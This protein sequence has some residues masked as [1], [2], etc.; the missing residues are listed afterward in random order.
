MGRRGKESPSGAVGARPVIVA[1]TS[2]FSW[3]HS[4]LRGSTH[5]IMISSYR[6]IVLRYEANEKRLDGKDGCCQESPSLRVCH[7]L[8]Y[9]PK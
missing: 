2:A 4:D 3:S 9:S 7:M 6:S 1:K 5:S 8:A